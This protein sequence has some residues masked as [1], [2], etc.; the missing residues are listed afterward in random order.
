[1]SSFRRTA[2]GEKRASRGGSRGSFRNR[3][4]VPKDRAGS[5]VILIPGEYPDPRPEKREP[6]GR[7]PVSP[8]HLCKEHRKKVSDKQYPITDICSAGWDENNPLPCVYCHQKQLGDISVDGGPNKKPR[9]LYSFNLVH[10]DWYHL[11]PV[12]DRRTNQVLMNPNDNKPYMTKVLCEDSGCQHCRDNREKVFGAKKYMQLGMNHFENLRSIDA[13]IGEVCLG[14]REGTVTTASFECPSCGH[15]IIDCVT[16]KYTESEID[17]FSSEPLTCSACRHTDYAVETLECS[18]CQDPARTGLFDV[19]LWLRRQGESTA[20]A[21]SINHP[22]PKSLG[23]EFRDMYKLPDGTDL[24]THY[25]EN[26][27]GIHTPVWSKLVSA[28]MSPYDFD[29]MVGIGKGRSAVDQAKKLQ[30]ANPFA[31]G[32]ADPQPYGN[33]GSRGPSFRQ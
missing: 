11:A 8:Y 5:P 21:L 14:C 19:V 10:L 29:S 6:D 18:E 12:V 23:W 31:G 7:P 17:T 16:N 30:I 24:V 20:S 13:D 27:D 15:V 32:G 26:E 2:R 3:Y 1:M 25:E 33:D 9:I 22:S 4:T 28:L